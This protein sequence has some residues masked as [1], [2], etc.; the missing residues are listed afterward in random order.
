MIRAFARFCAK[1]KQKLEKLFAPAYNHAIDRGVIALT[2]IVTE[3]YYDG[4]FFVWSEEYET[5]AICM[6]YRGRNFEESGIEI[7]EEVRFFPD[8]DTGI[9]N[10]EQAIPA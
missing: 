6:E 9:C 3:I 2:G 7:G 8:P 4:S 5:G 10:I 1:L